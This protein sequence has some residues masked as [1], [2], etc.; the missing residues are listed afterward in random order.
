MPSPELITDLR[1]RFTDAGY[2]TDQVLDR[3]G[4]AGQEGLGRNSTIPARVALQDAD[5]P[6][7]TM[8]ALWLL[9]R[10]VSRVAAEAALPL[11]SLVA[12][13]ILQ[14]DGDRVSAL[15]D[16][17]PYGSPD[18]GASGW[19]VCDLV[20]GL[21]GRVVPTR[22][23]FVLG[24]SPASS[25]LAQMTIRHPVATALDLGTGCGVQSLHLARHAGA[26]VAT[27]LN[28]RALELAAWS[29]ALSGVRLELRQ[30]SLYE[31]VA[32]RRFDLIVSN[33]PYVMS[34]P[35]TD[36]ERLV[37]REGTF[38]GDGLVEAV[39]RGAADH[40]FPGGTLQVLANWAITDQDWA[41]RLRGWVPA[42]CDALIMERERLS[43][44]EYIEMWLT[45]AGLAGSERWEPRYREWLGYFDH[46]GIIA[47]GMGWIEVQR[48]RSDVP[49]DIRV[50]QWPWAVQQP[51]GQ[52]FAAA[53]A[54]R[55]LTRR[56]DAEMLALAW[57]LDD[58]V[59]QETTGRPGMADPEHVVLRST[60]GFRRAI[61]VDTALG[62]V[63]GACDATLPLGTI[64]GAVAT[65]LEVDA[66]ALTEALLP[67]IREV[68]GH[69]M[70]TPAEPARQSG[71]A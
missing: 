8:I 32:G 56:T 19:V 42:G 54:G 2:L 9:Q 51:V 24:V 70:L 30:G 55:T 65:L 33:P 41:D 60:T 57:V 7:A 17:R 45:D 10:S 61:E 38:A 29:A 6:Q 11:G 58:A 26:V 3:I 59:I 53:Q 27:D 15:V 21:D 16:I 50:E 22:P 14:V 46:L 49:A 47:V 39:V 20:P 13:H 23:D 12:E 48:H 52:G 71:P 43:V 66:A 37:Y 18:D 40:L 68:I 34:P 1:T 36:A 25:T 62:G 64:I 35:A 44:H 31:P 69:G 67:P 5:D 28:P 63:L 4:T